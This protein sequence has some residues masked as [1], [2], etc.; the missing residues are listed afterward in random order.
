MAYNHGQAEYKW[1]LWKEKEEK[2]LRDNGVTEDT[3]E[4]IRSM[5]ARHLIQTDDIMSVCRKQ[6]HI[7]IR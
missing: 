5:T 7:W 4:A 1:K 6:V 3:I 2:I